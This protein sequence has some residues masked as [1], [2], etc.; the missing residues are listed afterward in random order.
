MKHNLD[1]TG[2]S[3]IKTEVNIKT[4]NMEID[5]ASLMKNNAFI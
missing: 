3:F 1:D 2:Y 4:F 5:L